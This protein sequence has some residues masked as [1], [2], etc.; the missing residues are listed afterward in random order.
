M[1]HQEPIVFCKIINLE[2]HQVLVKL[3]YEEDT[4]KYHINVITQF[5]FGEVA[6][7]LKLTVTERADAQRHLDQLNE[8]QAKQYVNYLSEMF[9]LGKPYEV[10]A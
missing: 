5:E 4:D 9:G 3:D 6:T 1:S 2:H 7:V 8:S 10:A